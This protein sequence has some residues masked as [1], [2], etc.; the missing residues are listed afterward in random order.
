LLFEV[1]AAITQ[2]TALPML[3]KLTAFADPAKAGLD[4]VV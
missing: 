3:W 1:R 2:R 4:S